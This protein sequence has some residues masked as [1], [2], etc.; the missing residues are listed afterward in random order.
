MLRYLYY[1][2][3]AT[4]LLA[5]TPTSAATDKIT[6]QK[7]LVATL[8]KQ[9][10]QGEREVANLRKSRA[11]SEVEVKSLVGQVEARNRLI[12][13][14]RKEEQLLRTEIST[15]DSTTEQLERQ[16]DQERV[17]YAQMVREAYRSYS[18]HNVLT[19]LFTAVDFQDMAHKVANLRAV[20]SLRAERIGRIDSL[21]ARLKG[22][23]E[24][25]VTRR[26]E[27]QS[28][29]SNLEQQKKGLEGD[30]ASARR[31][32]SSMSAKE[33]SVMRQNQ[34]QQQKL[35]AAVKELQKLIKGNQTGASFS[36]KSSNLNLPVVGG[37]VKQYKDNM[38]EIVGR[39]GA[40][41]VSIY[42]GKV[43]DVRLNRITGKYDV[44]I[45]HGE[46]ISSYAGLSSV[47]VEKESTVARGAAIGVIG[48]AVDI[49]TLES[50]HKIVFGIYPPTT[51]ETITAASCFKR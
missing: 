6:Q 2:C 48:E 32:I 26:G 40:Q 49:I 44:Y 16:L 10:A 17:Y 33:K 15:A 31:S 5:A 9:V 29:L 7:S 51:K 30:V 36:S 1:I 20:A 25:L 21:S 11:A 18:S 12:V 19:Y 38:A 39:E 37:R 35:A 14:Q 4:L 50:E 27:L 13:A 43:V 28:V 23:R 34:L 22:E 41:I 8:E 47:S 45:A 46:Y 3:L 24:Q 42:E